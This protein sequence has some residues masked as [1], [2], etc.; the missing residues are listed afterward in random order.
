MIALILVSC[1]NESHLQEKPHNGI[2]RQQLKKELLKSNNHF[3]KIEDQNI[4]DYIQR[5]AYKMTKT[6]TGLYYDIYKQGS[7][8]IAKEGDIAVLKYTVRLINGALVYDSN[9]NGLKEF[10]ISRGG[11]ESGLEEGILLLKLGDCARFILP[12]HLAFGLA[13]DHNMI[14]KKATLVYDIEL[15]NLK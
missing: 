11:V 7:G 13:G 12:S 1:E 4:K 5:H 14:P 15:I 8:P 2:S 9:Q 10:K 6:G 3:L